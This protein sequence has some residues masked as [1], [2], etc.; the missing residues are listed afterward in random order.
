MTG[1]SRDR[2]ARMR[3]ARTGRGAGRR[4][5]GLALAAA[6]LAAVYVSSGAVLDWLRVTLHG[7]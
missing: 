7:R 4:V 3:S 1:G 5:L 6:A 2:D